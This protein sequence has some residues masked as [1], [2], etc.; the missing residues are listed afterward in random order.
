[1]KLCMIPGPYGA[2]RDEE[3]N[4]V[5]IPLGAHANSGALSSYLLLA[6]IEPCPVQRV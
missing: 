4:M 2:Q 1:M 5:G 3:P 6:S